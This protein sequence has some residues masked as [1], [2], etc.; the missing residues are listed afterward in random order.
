MNPSNLTEEQLPIYTALINA[1]WIMRWTDKSKESMFA[2]LT[3]EEAEQICNNI[4]EELD[5]VGYQIVK[6]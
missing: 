5:K 6:K 2:V 1:I 3:T 4:I